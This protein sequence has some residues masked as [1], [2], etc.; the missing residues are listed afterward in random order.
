MKERFIYLDVM[1]GFTMFLVVFGHVG[2]FSFGIEPYD[3]T[4][5]HFF[6]TFRMPMFFFLSGYLGYK[7]IECWNFD[8]FK[9]RLKLKAFVQIIPMLIF[10][11]VFQLSRGIIPF[12]NLLS[13]GWE[14]YW[15][16]FVLFEMFLIYY[17]IAFLSH[18]MSKYTMLVL[19]PLA[20]AGIVLLAIGSRD[21]TMYNV[22]CLENLYKYFQ[23]FVLGLFFKKYNTKMIEYLKIE[24]IKC[25]IIVSFFVMYIAICTGALD[26]NHLLY[27]LVHDLVIRYTGVLL[28]FSFFLHLENKIDADSKLVKAFSY[29]GKHTLD[30]YLLHY[31]FLPNL[32]SFKCYF[33]NNQQPFFELLTCTIIASLI[34]AV[35]LGIQYVLS[36]SS[37]LQYWLFGKRT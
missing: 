3:S 27:S 11:T 15:F 10:Y 5:M 9:E 28:V 20:M 33:E 17:I 35:C 22:L 13:N 36:M 26:F 29:I 16:T 8:F 31:F 25:V 12:A 37:T 24:K 4:V 34:I 18:I 32:N 30:I 6:V 21:S 14:G 23:F 2:G 19:I 7:A 1:R